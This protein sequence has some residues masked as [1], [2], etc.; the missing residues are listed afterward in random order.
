MERRLARLTRLW[1]PAPCADCDRRPAIVCVPQSDSPVPDYPAGRCSERWTADAERDGGNLERTNRSGTA[2]GA[3]FV[4][5]RA[6]Y[7]AVRAA[8]GRRGDGRVMP[9]TRGAAVEIPFPIRGVAG[10]WRD[11]WDDPDD[12]AQLRR[13]AAILDLWEAVGAQART[14]ERTERR[15]GRREIAREATRKRRGGK[16]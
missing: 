14:D 12:S 16:S 6:L 2:G 9:A 13:Q 8:G 4:D 1:P 7:G 11:V 15:R 10:G 5:G 3:R